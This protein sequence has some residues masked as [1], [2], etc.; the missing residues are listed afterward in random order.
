[1]SGYSKSKQSHG[2][3]ARSLNFRALHAYWQTTSYT[4]LL[5]AP[6]AN[7]AAPNMISQIIRSR[8][9]G[10]DFDYNFSGGKDILSINSLE[11]LITQS[12][13][14]GKYLIGFMQQF[15]QNGTLQ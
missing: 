8:A 2:Q 14:P 1:Y 3:R 13:V 15:V 12:T 7:Q 9:C 5:S 10:Q 6:V 4:S 11:D